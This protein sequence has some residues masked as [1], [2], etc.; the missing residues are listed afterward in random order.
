MFL[1]LL[2]NSDSFAQDLPKRVDYHLSQIKKMEPW[3]LDSPSFYRGDYYAENG[4]AGGSL[5]LRFYK[6]VKSQ[7]DCFDGCVITVEDVAIKPEIKILR[8][9]EFNKSKKQIEGEEFILIP[10][11]IQVEKKDGW[12]YG[13]LLG[14]T[15]Y[16]VMEQ[17]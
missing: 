16:E 2:I 3:V 7:K 14:S 5:H 15:F 12:I 17:K 6:D 4:G 9:L 10:A 13:L 11:K 8:N 1:G